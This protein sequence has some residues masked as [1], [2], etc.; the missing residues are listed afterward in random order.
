MPKVAK[1]GPTRAKKIKV[2]ITQSA[3]PAINTDAGDVFS[4]TA[5]AQAITSMTTNLTGTPA[6][7]DI[8]VINWTD[9]GTGRAITFGTGFEASTVALPT[10][11]IANALLSAAFMYNGATSKWR[12]LAVA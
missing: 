9:N 6:H 3:T 11:T 4:M 12:C 8:I 5:L 1:G 2:T 10:T 7:G